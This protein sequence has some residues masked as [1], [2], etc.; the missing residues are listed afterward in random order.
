[1]KLTSEQ[2]NDHVYQFV[3]NATP[4][5]IDDLRAIL[6]RSEGLQGILTRE[7]PDGATIWV[8]VDASEGLCWH[9]ATP[10]TYSLVTELIGLAALQFNWCG[11][12]TSWM[13]VN[14]FT[15]AS[16]LP[17]FPIGGYEEYH[18]C[19]KW[20]GESLRRRLELLNAVIET[21]RLCLS[22]H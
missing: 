12:S 1:M 2:I 20:E 8:E 7:V 6:R 13:G 21:L 19:I 14:T 4:D 10:G 11:H 17:L 15:T 9:L 22:S 18:S 3:I 16:Y 5:A